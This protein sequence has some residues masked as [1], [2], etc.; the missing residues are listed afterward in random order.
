MFRGCGTL[1]I[2]TKVFYGLVAF[3]YNIFSKNQKVIDFGCI[4]ELN[5]AH[6]V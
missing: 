4:A 5:S 1:V 6:N 3:V 2:K